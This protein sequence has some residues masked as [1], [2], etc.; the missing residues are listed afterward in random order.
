M[1]HDLRRIFFLLALILASCGEQ[2]RAWAD[3]RAQYESFVS[4]AEIALADQCFNWLHDGN[5]HALA[6]VL[7]PSLR[8]QDLQNTLKFMADIVPDETPLGSDI[9][10]ARY[11][12]TTIGD[13]TTRQVTLTV[14]YLFP[15]VWVVQEITLVD[16]GS[17][18][19]VSFFTVEANSQS[20]QERNAL[21]FSAATR[22][23]L[24]SVLAVAAVILVPTFMLVTAFFCFRTP[25]PRLKWLW[26]IFI[27]LGF[28]TLTVDWIDGTANLQLLTVT[29]LAAG[30]AKAGTYGGWIF[31]VSFPLGAILFWLKRFGWIADH[32]RRVRQAEMELDAETF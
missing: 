5:L 16:Q 22:K 21:S 23:P 3:N 11:T 26:I 29:L 10:N 4:K 15:S 6:A 24:G 2:G 28:T 1:G 32:D 27:L 31:S 17:G 30:A 19:V 9:F 12:T 13:A 18:P 8:T 14:Q 7:D 25:V 20:L